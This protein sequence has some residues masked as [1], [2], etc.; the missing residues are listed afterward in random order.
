MLTGATSSVIELTDAQLDRAIYSLW[1]FQQG[2]SAITFLREE[3]DYSARYTAVE[4]RRF[5]CFETSAIISVAR[6]FEAGRGRAAISLKAL[7]IT[8]SREDRQLIRR[9]TLL[10]HKVVAHSDE[11]AMHYVGMT[12]KPFEERSIT[13]PLFRFRETLYLTEGDAR[14]LEV[15]LRKLLDGVTRAVFQIAQVSP[16]RFNVRKTP[17]VV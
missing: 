12:I 11:E 2:L 9:V 13:A 16:E 17:T 8:L 14:A 10:R 7:G 4:L 5:R 1:D 3:C 6:P 15:L